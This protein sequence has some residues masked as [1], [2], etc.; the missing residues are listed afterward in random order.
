MKISKLNFNLGEQIWFSGLTLD[1]FVAS[2]TQK[3][4]ILIG[5]KTLVTGKHIHV[6]YFLFFKFYFSVYWLVTW[7]WRLVFNYQTVYIGQDGK[8]N[9]SVFFNESNCF[10]NGTVKLYHE[11]SDFFTNWGDTMILFY[12][13]YSTILLGLAYQSRL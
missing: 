7:I 6:D 10:D 12:L 1:S 13:I 2:S 4:K 3:T 8:Y 5:Y 11:Y 9:E